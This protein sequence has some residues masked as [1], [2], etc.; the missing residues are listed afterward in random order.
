MIERITPDEDELPVVPSASPQMAYPAGELGEEDADVTGDDNA[1]VQRLAALS[2]MD[3]DRRREDEAKRLGVRVSTLDAEVQ[4]RRVEAKPPEAP[5]GFALDDPEP[6]PEPVD[7]AALLNNL[8]VLTRRHLVLPAGADIAVALWI[9]HT[10]AHDAASISPILAATSPA[11]ECGK[12]TLLTLLRA[13]VARPLSTS[14]ITSAAL[15]RSVEKWRPCV[16]VDE[17]D[18]FLHYNDDLRGIL[19]SG[20]NRHTASVIRTVGDDYEPRPFATWAPKAIAHIGRLPAT[21]ESRSIHVELRRMGPAETVEPLRPDRLDHL[22][23]HRRKARRWALDNDTTLRSAE[24][25]MPMGLR[26]RRADNWRALLAIADAAGGEWP[27]LARN[28][29]VT[30]SVDREGDTAG[31]VLLRDLHKLFATGGADRLRSDEI[32]RDLGAMEDR[33]W[34]EWKS[35]K[36]ITPRQVAKLLGPFGIAPTTIRTMAGTAKGYLASQ[37]EDA[38]RRY[39]PDLSVTP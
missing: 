35:G 3:Y 38:F 39:L 1:V 30:L 32:A 34:P 33:P 8:R 29:A 13:L 26:G 10:H 28:A 21:L 9:V 24:P 19:D 12:T 20:H 7:G 2:P 17:A 14:N 18:T 15:F 37:F 6:W 22:E 27:C 11:P 25:E 4:K 23:T 5:C 31:I 16:L 36:P